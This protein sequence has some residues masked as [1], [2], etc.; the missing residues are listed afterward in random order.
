M[1]AKVEI[2]NDE[3][4]LQFDKDN[5]NYIFIG[6]WSGLS[7]TYPSKNKNMYHV[8][9]KNGKLIVQE[10]IET[11][12][13]GGGFVEYVMPPLRGE[14]NINKLSY[15]VGIPDWHWYVG[16]GIFLEDVDHEI[17]KLEKEIKQELQKT[18]FSIVLLV[19]SFSIVLVFFY[20][21]LSRKIKRDFRTFTEFFDSLSNKD[22]I[23]DL[24]S[25]KFREFDELARHAN[26][27]LQAKLAINKI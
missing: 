15:V 4:R 12:Q 14:R 2:A 3:N 6:E 1:K 19:L 25:I 8:T 11:A 20:L 23:I 21:Y 26:T 17:A 27:M 10:L 7:L 13:N 18:I 16:A 24:Q 9:D 22:E 5:N